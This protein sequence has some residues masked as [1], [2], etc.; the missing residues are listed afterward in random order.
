EAP[1]DSF[2]PKG[3]VVVDG[4]KVNGVA[5]EIH[6]GERVLRAGRVVEK[7]YVDIIDGVEGGEGSGLYSYSTGVLLASTERKIITFPVNDSLKYALSGMINGAVLIADAV[8]FD[9]D[10]N[11]LGYNERVESGD[12]QLNRVELELPSGTAFIGTGNRN[13]YD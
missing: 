2:I 8:Y 12:V 13:Q 4:N 3:G 10:M 9:S 6:N 7:T 5:L 1:M 11:Y